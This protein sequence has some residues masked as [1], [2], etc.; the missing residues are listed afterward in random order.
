VVLIGGKILDVVPDGG[1]SRMD[2]TAKDNVLPTAK[3]RC[4]LSLLTKE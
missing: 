3:N 4:G 1:G 2:R